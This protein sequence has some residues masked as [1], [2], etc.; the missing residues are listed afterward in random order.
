MVFD[1]NLADIRFGTGLS[2]SIASPSSVD[3][4]LARLAGPDLIARTYP[5]ETYDQLRD[6]MMQ[7]RTLRKARNRAKTEAEREKLHKQ[8]RH[9]I[10]DARRGQA[11]WLVQNLARRSYTQDGFRERLAGFWSD[12]FTVRGKGGVLRRSA[13]PN[14][15]S[16][17]RP[18]LNGP[19]SDLLIAAATS[20][21]MLNFLD[22]MYSV[23]PAAAIQTKAKA[24]GNVRGLNENLAREILE[25]HTL[26][27]NGP[28]SQTDV[29]QLAEL[30]TGLS[31]SKDFEGDF[32]PNWAEPG[33]ETVLGTNYGGDPAEL[34]D[35]HQVLTD[36]SVHPAT[37]RHLSQKLAT[38][39][40]A[41]TPS[42]G[43][44]RAMTDAWLD[45]GGEL[46]QVYRAMLSHP[47]AWSA[48]RANVKPPFDFISSAMRALAVPGTPFKGKDNDVEQRIKRH[49]I[50]PLRRMGQTFEQPQG[51]DGWPE[52]DTFWI[53][54][55]GIA[56]RMEWAMQTPNALKRKDLPDPRDFVEIAL[57]PDAPDAVRFAAGAAEN[58]QE[59]IALVLIS[60]AFQRR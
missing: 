53:T 31:L 11:H 20:P 6:R 12:H 30:L 17:V 40:I 24:N 42:D 13:L 29:R 44:V 23:G 58:R 34:A 25:L 28:Y 49:F 59:G 19:F 1:P 33:A 7:A 48:Q 56:A 4:M 16:F 32:K 18:F 38:H 37:A 60:P 35:I 55:Q 43:M 39:F 2:P 46:A 14:T 10:R 8:F 57:G 51:P 45:T 54:P 52:E 21:V 3:Q 36:L 27:V 41:D 47:A 5:I 50:Q 26:G 22:Q 9:V 15:E